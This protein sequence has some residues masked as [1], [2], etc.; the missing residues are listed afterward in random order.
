VLLYII[1][2]F[3][4]HIY[5]HTSDLPDV[6]T[7]FFKEKTCVDYIY[8]LCNQNLYTDTYVCYTNPN[9]RAQPV[10]NTLDLRGKNMQWNYVF[11]PLTCNVQRILAICSNFVFCGLRCVYLF[12]IGIDFPIPNPIPINS[13]RNLRDLKTLVGGLFFFNYFPTNIG[14]HRPNWLI[15]FIGVGLNHQPDDNLSHH[16]THIR[17]TIIGIITYYNHWLTH[18]VQRGW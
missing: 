7:D 1:Y 13:L 11:Q 5:I 9:F 10:Q 12:V 16:I 15:F 17:T 14:N 4:R 8:I 6:Y 2:L 3:I 18:I